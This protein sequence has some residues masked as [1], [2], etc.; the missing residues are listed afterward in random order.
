ME[1][2]TK[3]EYVTAVLSNCSPKDSMSLYRQRLEQVRSDND[4]L[5]YWIRERTEIEKQYSMNLHKLAMSMQNTKSQSMSFHDAWQQ[6]EAETLE[7]AKYSNQM[8]HQMGSQIYKPLVEYYTSSPQTAAVRELAERLTNIA[9][10]ISPNQGLTKISKSLKSDT[11]NSRANWDAEAP[12]AFEKLQN[13]DEEHLLMLKQVYSSIAS[14]QSDACAS[15]QNLLSKSMEVYME[16]PIENEIKKFSE[17]AMLVTEPSS[18]LGTP[19]S[20]LS[21]TEDKPKEHGREGN[22]KSRVTTLFRRKTI[23]KN[24]NRSSPK[25]PKSPRA[26]K[27]GNLFGKQGKDPNKESKRL[28]SSPAANSSVP[29]L[30][31]QSHTSS[32]ARPVHDFRV[33]HGAS[34][35]ETEETIRP[36]VSDRNRLSPSLDRPDLY[37]QN[38]ISSQKIDKSV[39]K[40]E[41]VI[42]TER[43]EKNDTP[44]SDPGDFEPANPSSPSA[45][46]STPQIESKQV[47]GSDKTAIDN[48]SSTLRRNT[49]LSRY[50][51]LG[52]ANN[53]TS[54]DQLNDLNSLPNLSTLSLQSLNRQESLPGWLPE[55][56]KTAGLS[57]AI[58][59]TFSG[60]LTDS[61]LLHPSCFG[62]VYLKYT[63]N[64][65][66][67]GKIV[68]IQL[69]SGFPLSIKMQDEERVQPSSSHDCFQ[70]ATGKLETPNPA[71]T[72]D[73][74]L[75]SVNGARSIPLTV[76]QKWK[77]EE[78]A[79]SMIAFVK[80]NAAWKDLG[81]TLSLQKLVMTVYLGENIIVKGCQSSPAGEF[82]RKTSKLKLYFSEI[83]VPSSGFKVLAHFDVSPSTAIR[84]PVIGL[85]FTMNDKSNDAGLVKLLERP[86]FES[87]NSS[88]RS[89]LET[90]Y[91]QKAVPTFYISQIRDCIFYA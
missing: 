85:H 19:S 81:N 46:P 53:S 74:Q 18:N 82:S 59:E 80:P 7:T 12:L 27:L 41:P 67:F 69:A 83:T 35:D 10:E 55:L 72:Y 39:Q 11:L 61:G 64:I 91:E 75:D 30:S 26:S 33:N 62:T 47:P 56:P 29:S 57:A 32:F 65:G 49:S 54:T 68:G 16:L 77:H 40:P 4:V 45:I 86:E 36:N 90:A 34:E 3:T 9:N 78:T 84:K 37:G 88:H 44:F 43:M 21:S 60:E 13:L 63:P 48:V 51:S 52:R 5:G 20:L 15:H 76:V 24:S 70:L 28:A 79:S 42:G 87:P 2:L 89:V 25:S 8:T 1:S 66:Q 71:L 14:L 22:L 17:S 23:A 58:V 73:L 50:R 6:L 31:E 38:N